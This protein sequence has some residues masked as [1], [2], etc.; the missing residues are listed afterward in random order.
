MA[1]SHWKGRFRPLI[2]A[3]VLWRMAAERTNDMTNEVD[4]RVLNRKGAR[5]LSN[6][7]MLMVGGGTETLK[8]SHLPNGEVDVLADS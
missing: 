7:E 2:E 1:V 5:T 8:F 4:N 6:E 3:T